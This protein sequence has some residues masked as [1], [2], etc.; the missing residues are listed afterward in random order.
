MS[1]IF[2]HGLCK[3]S[4]KPVYIAGKF[5]FDIG[6]NDMPISITSNAA[7]AVAHRNL[8]TSSEE[9]QRSISKISSGNRV[10]RA[11]EDAGALSIAT[12]FRKESSVYKAAAIN[13]Q[14][15]I[16]L[17]QIA[18]G[19]LSQMT[20]VLD[21]MKTLTIQS[22]SDSISNV[23]R[24]YLDEEF[25]TLKDEFDRIASSTEFNGRE[26]L[27]G[28]ND[29]QLNTVGA[30]IDSASGFVAFDFRE[31]VDPTSVFEVE[32]DA[33]VNMM[34][35]HNAVT[36][37]YQSISVQAPTTGRLNVYNFSDLGVEL[38]LNSAF[39]DATDIVHAGVGE[40]FDVVASAVAT[41]SVYEF[42]VGPTTAAEDRIVV[43]LPLVNLT[44]L[45]LGT[46][47]VASSSAAALASTAIDAAISVISEARS[48]LGA[49]MNRMEIASV[50]IQN[51]M[52][53]VEAAKSAV[54]DVDVA[55]E[56]T[57]MTAQQLLME[58]G[59]SMLTSANEQ[60]RIL[61]GLLR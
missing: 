57:N 15:G 48:G 11:K 55:L 26:L 12:G 60:P 35:L 4:A 19:S 18:D 10:F 39:D 20:E 28:V 61:L 1:R 40:E 17:M 16:S 36:N 32:Y 52:E 22:Q 29:V 46:S 54:L 3:L 53:N 51:S 56:I 14:S 25:Q 37:V 43:N 44:A 7:S 13:A 6:D 24:A 9:S 45:G 49:S 47:D 38:T 8:A 41:A 50:N 2:W 33:T 59:T 58:A 30:N 5:F 21:R 23:E 42:Q 31:F 27:G 34:T